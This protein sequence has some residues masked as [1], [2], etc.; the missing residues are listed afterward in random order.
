MIA[1]YYLTRIVK[2]QLQSSEADGVINEKPALHP[3]KNMSKNNKYKFLTERVNTATTAL[4]FV[5]LM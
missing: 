2:K 1:C 3:G 5:S 4:R